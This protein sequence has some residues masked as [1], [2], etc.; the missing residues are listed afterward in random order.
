MLRGIYSG[1]TALSNLERQHEIVASNLAH[2]NTTG[3]R[4]GVFSLSQSSETAETKANP[5][6][7]FTQTFDFD[8]AGRLQHTERKL[9]IALS[10][11]GF[12]EFQ[13]TNGNYYSRNGV[14]FRAANG[15]LQ[16][17]EGHA[18]MSDNGP[19]VI[20]AEIPES[21]IHIGNDGTV[22]ANGQ[23]VGTI[24]L[25]EF[26]DYQKLVSHSPV[27]FLAGTAIP[28]PAS[29]TGIVQG[30]RELSNANPLM[31]M[32]NL[33]IVSRHLESAQRA[34]RTISD[35]VQQSLQS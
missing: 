14:L 15:Q 13:G 21:Q 16:N 9:D 30:A 32:I 10:G 7:E 4:R 3:H 5:G 28:S 2:L 20:P 8:T 22:S 6:A 11:P 27:D 34:I 24:K 18:L 17:R 12:L 23:P 31:E 1:S 35:S 26:D 33:I 29:E 19:L 25:V